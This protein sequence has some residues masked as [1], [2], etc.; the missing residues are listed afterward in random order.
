MQ[1][2]GDAEVVHPPPGVTS[3]EFLYYFDSPN[4]PIT[5]LSHSNLVADGETVLT[6]AQVH[7]L[8]SALDAIHNRFS[9]AYGPARGNKGWY[10]MD[11]EF[12][13]DGDAG[14]DTD[15]VRQASA[16]APRTRLGEE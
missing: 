1:V 3:D 7:E 6:A 5:Y 13:F 8:G 12:K 10:A 15:A 9:A 4:Q 11:V 14:Q 16:P 2:G